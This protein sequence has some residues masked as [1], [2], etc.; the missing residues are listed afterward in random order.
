MKASIII[1]ARVQSSRLHKKSLAT[2]G[3]YKVI[4]W[5]FKRLKLCKNAE[6]IIL[7]TTQKSEDNILCK[8]A[9]ENGILYFR[10]DENNVLKRYIDAANNFK[11]KIIV[12][13]CAD[14]P[15]VDPILIDDL[16]SS[17]VKSTDD[18]LFNHKSDDINFWP[19][20]FGG[21]IF[22]L[23][24]LKRIY[25]SS[26]L[27]K[28][29]EHVTLFLYNNSDYHVNSLVNRSRI[30]CNERFDLDTIEDYKKLFNLSK[31]I[32]LHDDYLTIINKYKSQN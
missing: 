3:R 32:L 19:Y 16:I 28:F 18:L 24:T 25:T 6:N 2:L 13:I 17:F 12:R 4:E 15:F 9:E 7:A 27:K 5:V 11:S 30:S 20:G 1:Q 31:D 10:G 21:E 23:K 22:K 8:I 29:K 26:L 14:R